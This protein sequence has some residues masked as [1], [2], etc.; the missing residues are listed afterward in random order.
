MTTINDDLINRSPVVI[1][2]PQPKASGRRS[3]QL[4]LGPP[5]NRTPAPS[6]SITFW[7]SRRVRHLQLDN[8]LPHDCL[9]SG[10][11][12]PIAR[13]AW[14]GNGDQLGAHHTWLLTP[15]PGEST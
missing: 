5:G 2:A 7:P 3:S 1:N 6:S 9:Q 13:L 4:V 8:I 12:F 10:R 11:V 15:R 14:Y